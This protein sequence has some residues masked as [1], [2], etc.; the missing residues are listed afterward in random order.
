MNRYGNRVDKFDNYYFKQ[1]L[2]NAQGV[3]LSEALNSSPALLEHVQK[4]AEDKSAYHETFKKSFVKLC[5]LGS[6]AESL[7]DIEYFLMDDPR[8]KLRFPNAYL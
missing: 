7:E 3:P 2:T 5:D 1:V 6:D 4:F 8:N